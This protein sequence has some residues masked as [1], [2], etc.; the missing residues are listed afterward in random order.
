[1]K[2]I[3]L[4]GR[5][6]SSLDWAQAKSEGA[7][8]AS[9]MWM[10]DLGLFGGLLKPLDDQ[11]QFLS[12]SLSLQHFRDTLWREF[13]ETTHSLCVYDGSVDFSKHFPWDEKQ[14]TNFLHW[15]HVRFGN[16]QTYGASREAFE[17]HPEGRHILRLFC[18][19]TC[20][21]YIQLLAN[22]LPDS[23]KVSVRLAVDGLGNLLQEAQLL[24]GDRYERLDL[25]VKGGSIGQTAKAS[26]AICIPPLEM[27][28]PSQF[29]GIEPALRYLIDNRIP[30]RLIP[31]NH[32]ITEWDNLDFLIVS[33]SGLGAQGKRKLQGFA[34]A[35][36]TVVVLGESIGVVGELSY[37]QWLEKHARNIIN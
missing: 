8:N 26:V 19:D 17:N 25:I 20:V 13:Q 23:M 3:F 22:R 2:H 29:E 34:A 30:Y 35:G 32:L 16:D 11:S 31:E 27:C 24:S 6:Q 33:P 1:M 14:W 36:G 9:I 4:D 10:M 21:E 7:G 15:F 5:I 37:D 18:R 12:L 28:R